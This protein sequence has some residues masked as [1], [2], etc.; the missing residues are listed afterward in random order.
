MPTLHLIRLILIALWSLSASCSSAQILTNEPA[1]EVTLRVLNRD[2]MTFRASLGTY[3]PEQRAEAAEVRIA[4]A[5]KKSGSPRVDSRIVDGNAELRVHGQTVFFILPKDV[6]ELEGETLDTVVQQTEQR[7]SRVVTELEELHNHQ[8]LIKSL[9][10]GLSATLGLAVFIWLL[11]RNR[12]WVEGRLIKLTSDKADQIKSHSLRLFGLQNLVSLLR[13]CT[14][15]IFWAATLVATYLWLELLLRLFPMTRPF[16]EQ[17]QEKFLVTAGKLG[18]N[19]LHALPNLGIV[20]LVFLLA[21]FASTAS[22]RFFQTIT[23]GNI[24]SRFF[25]TTTAPIAQRLATILI[26]L[27]AI[28]VAFPYIPGSQTPAFR[29]ISVLAGLMISLGSGNLI[30]Q[31]VG[32][33]TMIYNRTCRPGDFVRIGEHEGTITTVGFFSSRLVTGRNEE[34]VLPNSQI[35]GGTLINYS[36]LNETAGVQVP[37]TVTIGYNTP[38]RQVHAMLLEAARRTPGL[39]AEPLPKVMQTALSDFYVEYELR[40]TLEKPATRGAT[41]S[42]LHAHVQDVFNEYGV[43]IMSPHYEADPAQ[44]VTVPKSKW[45]E[46]PAS[47]A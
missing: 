15:L 16:G 5:I 7:L 36:R 10:Y 27:T 13:G 30:A 12:R 41:L 14:T 29:G 42:E 26:W 9:A 25:D 18:Q 45:H 47:P 35:S 34:I 38:W 28:I 4:K 22:R 17:L 23:R 33:L 21:R 3:S 8:S 40:V 43:Q 2:V 1:A 44:P 24:K 32:G 6:N 20:L 39:K 46:P 19:A 11:A 31:L 37:V